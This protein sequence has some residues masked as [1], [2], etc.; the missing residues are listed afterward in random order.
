MR[1]FSCTGNPRFSGLSGVH[2]TFL[3]DTCED[4]LKRA[5]DKPKLPLYT[6]PHTN[7]AAGNE[8]LKGMGD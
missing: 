5:L 1:F 7:G 3:S 8:A 2:R 4:F 6:P